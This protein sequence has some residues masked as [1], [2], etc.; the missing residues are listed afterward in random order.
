MGEPRGQA[1]GLHR[2]DVEFVGVRLG[3]ELGRGR[4]VGGVLLVSDPSL[5]HPAFPFL[6]LA[7][8]LFF[9]EAA[10]PLVIKS[11]RAGFLTASMVVMVVVLALLLV[12][13]GAE[14]ALRPGSST[15]GR[16]G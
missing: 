3:G 13:P 2:L 10:T 8:L 15:G 5:R 4:S 7:L 6:H 16:R 12:A 1:R 11:T 9:F 14:P